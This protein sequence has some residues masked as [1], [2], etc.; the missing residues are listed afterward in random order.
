MIYEKRNQWYKKKT[1]VTPADSLWQVKIKWPEQGRAPDIS[2]RWSKSRDLTKQ[3]SRNSQTGEFYGS[4][5]NT[6]RQEET[7]FEEERSN[8]TEIWE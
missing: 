6:D 4:E 1:P 8:G 5:K 3:N 2:K 7:P